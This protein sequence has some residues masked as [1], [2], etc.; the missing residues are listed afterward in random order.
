MVIPPRSI[1][2][3]KEINNKEDDQNELEENQNNTIDDDK[4]QI[5]QEVNDSATNNEEI[6]SNWYCF[7]Y[8]NVIY[9]DLL[10][11]ILLNI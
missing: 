5:D 11:K 8:K 7:D 9:T 6:N 2:I 1:N 10:F 3:E 4:S